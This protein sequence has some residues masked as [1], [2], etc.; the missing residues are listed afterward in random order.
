[1]TDPLRDAY[2]LQLKALR[3]LRREIARQ[4]RR[5]DDLMAA[6]QYA[7]SVS[8]AAG[9]AAAYAGQD[10]GALSPLSDHPVAAAP[11]RVPRERRLNERPEC[12]THPCAIPEDE[13]EMIER[14]GE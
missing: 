9:G 5:Y 14:C 6:I 7:S 11:L 13:I 10:C 3:A 4:D 2:R 1:M 8:G 12:A